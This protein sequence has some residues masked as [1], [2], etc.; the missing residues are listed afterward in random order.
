MKLAEAL[1]ERKGAKEC[2]DSL[3]ERIKSSALIQ[4]GDSPP[5]NPEELLKELTVAVEQL[6]KLIRAINRSNNVAQLLDHTT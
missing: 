4:E 1:L 6:G 2:I 5:E 3:R